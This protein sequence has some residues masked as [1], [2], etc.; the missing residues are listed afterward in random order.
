MSSFDTHQSITKR[1]KELS[2]KLASSKLSQHELEEFEMLSRSLYER[3]IILNY[4]AKEANVYGETESKPKIEIPKPVLPKPVVEAEKVKVPAEPKEIEFDF[5]GNFGE[6]EPT[7][8]NK[9]STPVGNDE[10]KKEDEV[11]AEVAET[12]IEEKQPVSSDKIAVFNNH[13]LNAYNNASTD[14]LSHSKISSLKGAFGLNDK[15]LFIRALFGGS[16]DDFNSVVDTLEEQSG[17]Q[18]ALKE[19]SRIAIERNW[20]KEDNTMDEFAHLV[21]R[22]Y[23]D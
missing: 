15:M 8:T 4:K 23:V 22:R 1:L 18:E 6:V 19:L 7:K 12:A 2:E 10:V 21:I 9:P 5:S 16:A 13:F 20:D 11:V 17:A 14:K 3:A